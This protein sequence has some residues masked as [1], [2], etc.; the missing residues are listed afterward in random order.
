MRQ[1]NKHGELAGLSGL[2]GLEAKKH[3]TRWV[4][5]RT[6][7]ELATDYIGTGYPKAPRFQISSPPKA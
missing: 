1:T 2:A 5:W 4:C 7:I 3:F 6:D